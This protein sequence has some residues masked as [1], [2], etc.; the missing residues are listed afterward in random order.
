MTHEVQ[1]VSNF[2]Y[3]PAEELDPIIEEAMAETN[4]EQREVWFAL[5]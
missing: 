1:N 4:R 3:L 5:A 2:H